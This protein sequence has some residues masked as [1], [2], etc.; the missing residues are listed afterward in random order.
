MANTLPKLIA[1]LGAESTG[2]T[3]LA[4][5]LA[6]HF[7]CPWVAEYLR[8]FCNEKKR[9]PHISEQHDIMKVQAAREQ[10]ALTIAT[11]NHA[12]YV[13]CDTAP[14]LTAIYSEYVFADTSLYAEAKALHARYT[15]TIVLTPDIEWVEDGLQRAGEHVRGDIHRLIKHTLG[16]I[17]IATVEVS[18]QGELRTRNAI[19]GLQNLPIPSR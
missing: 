5:A 7:N 8:D 6:A 18:G 12:P 10:R 11:A 15:I 1:I 16:E 19:E 3:T 13:F 17:N 4:Q 14:L 2:K 9:T